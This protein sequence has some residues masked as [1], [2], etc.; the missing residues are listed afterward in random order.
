MKI[1]L[2]VTDGD[3]MLSVGLS[4]AELVDL[5][6]AI[7]HFPPQDDEACNWLDRIEAKLT[8]AL[9]GYDDLGSR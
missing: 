9:S 4:R 1:W 5:V 2:T 3:R 7:E 6:F 8:L